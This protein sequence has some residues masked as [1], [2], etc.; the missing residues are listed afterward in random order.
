MLAILWRY[1]MWWIIPL[2]VIVIV[3]GLLLFLALTSD[4]KPFVYPLF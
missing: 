2:I 4:N 1:R 3:L